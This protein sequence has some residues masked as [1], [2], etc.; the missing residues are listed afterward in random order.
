MDDSVLA[1]VRGLEKSDGAMYREIHAAAAIPYLNKEKPDPLKKGKCDLNHKG[2]G[3]CARHHRRF[4][5]ARSKAQKAA[6]G[7]AGAGAGVSQKRKAAKAAKAAAK[8]AKKKAK[9]GQKAAPPKKVAAGAGRKRKRKQTPAAK[10]KAKKKQKKKQ[11]DVKMF[12]G[13]NTKGGAN[14][15]GSR[16]GRSGGPRGGGRRGRR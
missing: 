5:R 4:F 13:H 2:F 8:A 16:R 14:F 12:D 9:V 11:P 6:S 7:K 3:M 1:Y 15:F 10:A